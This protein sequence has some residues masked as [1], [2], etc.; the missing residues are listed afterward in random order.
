MQWKKIGLH[1]GTPVAGDKSV[2]PTRWWNHVWLVFFG[3][4]MIVT[5]RVPK[6]VA[7][8]GYFVGFTPP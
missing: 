4:K 5:F 6:E 3:W 7:A 8:K 2:P 1:E